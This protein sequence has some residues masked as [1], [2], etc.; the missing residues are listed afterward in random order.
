MDKSEQVWEDLKARNYIDS[1][2]KIQDLL[3]TD[4]KNNEVDLPE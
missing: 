1:K 3:R 2:G 4:L